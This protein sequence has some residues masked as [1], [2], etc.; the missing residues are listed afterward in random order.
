[1]TEPAPTEWRRKLDAGML[2]VLHQWEQRLATASASNRPQ[3]AG[4][5][6]NVIV[7]L[8]QPVGTD[9]DVV[10]AAHLNL[11]LGLPTDLGLADG[12]AV[13]VLA[14]G[15]IRLAGIAGL[16]EKPSVAKLHLPR[17]AHYT[18]DN[19]PTEIG[20]TPEGNGVQV[21]SRTYTGAGVIAAVIDTGIDIFHP[22]FRRRDGLGTRILRILD[23]TLLGP[24]PKN[25]GRE[26]TADA[27]MRAITA[28]P[29][30]VGSPFEH[31]DED[32]HGTHV[33]ACAAGLGGYS[34]GR[35]RYDYYGVAPDAELVVVKRGNDEA[36]DIEALRYIESIAY[37]MRM[38]VVVNMSF[39]GRVG[40]RDGSGPLEREINRVTARGRINAVVAS[41]GNAQSYRAHA[42]LPRQRSFPTERWAIVRLRAA[43]VN[44]AGSAGITVGGSQRN[45]DVFRMTVSYNWS[46]AITLRL[47]AADNNGGT[48]VGNIDIEPGDE[49]WREFVP[50]Y[51]TFVK[52]A[53][54]RNQEGNFHIEIVIQ[55][56]I[57]ASAAT[58]SVFPELISIEILRFD[59]PDPLPDGH[60]VDMWA[61]FDLDPHH[62]FSLPRFQHPTP[63]YT[64]GHP[65]TAAN[66]I[67]VGSFRR[68]P[69]PNYDYIASDSSFGRRRRQLG[70]QRFLPDLTAPGVLVVAARSGGASS[71]PAHVGNS[72]A[73]SMSGT[74]MA[75]P[76]VSG[77]VALLLEMKPDLDFENIRRILRQSASKSEIIDAPTA[78]DPPGLT[79]ANHKWGAGKVDATAALHQLARE[80][81]ARTVAS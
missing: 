8:A 2:A 7:D 54:Q 19:I 75:A 65:S 67:C 79:T 80:I 14:T 66:A 57:E 15:R 46:D 74:S 23:Q 64:V 33:A 35:R 68:M 18:L 27:I 48:P 1:M 32:G 16:A 69:L 76:L 58:A 38:P 61:T 13:G 51:D 49:G 53:D 4:E 6:I 20:I 34:E 50:G 72:L 25:Y 12:S 26:F 43:A 10:I 55:A 73:T 5:T 36:S 77:V 71:L 41:A 3:V 28:H 78:L 44:S 24:K 81:A 17:V 29:N 63:I 39:S 21:A 52:S 62:T 9:D 37:E 59:I 40:V 42:V 60:V 30:G 56:R 45:G 47:I 11:I 22:A 70:N 31:R